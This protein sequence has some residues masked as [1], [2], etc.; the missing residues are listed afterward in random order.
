[1]RTCTTKAQ[2][3]R[4]PPLD[5]VEQI[6]LTSWTGLIPTT[7]HRAD[8]L[9][10][11]SV[12]DR[13]KRKC[14]FLLLAPTA[15]LSAAL[16]ST[17]AGKNNRNPVCPCFGKERLPIQDHTASFDTNR[18]LDDG[19]C[20]AGNFWTV[21]RQS[22]HLARGHH[23]C[24]DE[25]Q[26]N[27]T[28]SK[29]RPEVLDLKLSGSDAIRCASHPCCPKQQPWV[30]TRSSAILCQTTPAVQTRSTDSYS[31]D[32]LH[33]N[34]SVGAALPVP[35][36]PDTWYVSLWNQDAVDL[37]RSVKQACQARAVF[38]GTVAACRFTQ[39]RK[40]SYKALRT[41]DDTKLCT[42]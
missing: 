11:V 1:M 6:A 17:I 13:K 37:Q 23:H 31:A 41:N 16:I 28:G 32:I 19:W 21:A 36:A 2:K 33:L 26:E 10:S 24:L 39:R 8:R 14:C 9:R 18:C 22:G 3:A 27:L 15:S 20:L 35:R 12:L 42:H 40:M 29:I 5:A 7:L 38:S 25:S 4:L 30:V 34:M